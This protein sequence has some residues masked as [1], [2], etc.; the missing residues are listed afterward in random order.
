[1]GA[2]KR[3]YQL[4]NGT[5]T[6]AKDWTIEFYID[7]KRYCQTVE[8]TNKLSKKQANKLCDEL[9]EKKKDQLRGTPNTPLF[10]DALLAYYQ[11]YLNNINERRANTHKVVQDRYNSKIPRIMDNFSGL[12]LDS[13]PRSIFIDYIQQRRREGVKDITIK[14]EIDMVQ[15]AYNYGETIGICDYRDIPNFKSIKKLLRK[16]KKPIRWLMPEEYWQIM[17][18]PKQN[19]FYNRQRK[20]IVNVALFTGMRKEEYLSILPEEHLNFNQSIIGVTDTKNG[21]DRMLP[22]CRLVKKQLQEQLQDIYTCGIETNHLFCHPNGNRIYDFDGFGR[23]CKK[24]GVNGVN[25]HTLR[26]TY[27]TWELIKGKKLEKVSAHLG[28]SSLKVTQDDYVFLDVL[29]QNEDFIKQLQ[30][31]LQGLYERILNE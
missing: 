12:R 28:H 7:G 31:Q 8:G 25:I 14:D 6:E 21:K 22:M 24:A 26:K 11:N 30:E 3:K 2:F 19:T 17:S 23:D 15:A 16:S 18:L 27:G 13:I 10:E 5:T 20:R 9:K 1:M 29:L 4:K